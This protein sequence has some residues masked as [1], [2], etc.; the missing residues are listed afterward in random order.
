MYFK[1]FYKDK[2]E[3]E[4]NTL[5]EQEGFKPSKFSDKPGTEYPTHQ[6]P[7]T[8]LLAFLEG[9]MCVTVNGK[10]Y[11]CRF[12]DKLLIPGNTPHSAFVEDQGCTFFWAEKIV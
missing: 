2:T 5:I 12:G 11:V 4:I 9:E 6:H 3:D 10:H 1:N 7:E 8:K